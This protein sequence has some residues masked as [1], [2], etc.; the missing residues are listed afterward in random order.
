MDMYES[1][2]SAE[3]VLNE[4]IARHVFESIGQEGP[5]MIIVD[6]D[7]HTWPSNSEHFSE[8]HLSVDLLSSFCSRIDD[9]GDPIDIAIDGNRV[10]GCQLSTESVNCGYLF[11]IIDK[12]MSKQDNLLVS[13]MEMLFNMTRLVANLIERNNRMYEQQ[14]RQINN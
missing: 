4:Q 9:G 12:Q 11:M 8:F 3:S 14:I 7:G 6:R 2:F 10:V 1:L 13:L 5:L